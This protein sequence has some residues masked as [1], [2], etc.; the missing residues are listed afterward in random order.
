M[1][2]VFTSVRGVAAG[3]GTTVQAGRLWIRFPIRSL[4]FLI[5]I[6]LPA[7]LRPSGWLSLWGKD[8]R[9]EGLKTLPPSWILETLTSWNSQGPSRPVEGLLYFLLCLLAVWLQYG[10]S[11]DRGGY[12]T[13]IAEGHVCVCGEPESGQS[14]IVSVWPFKDEA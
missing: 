12:G 14:V 6:N 9:C 3:W 8:G 4:E 5:D 2:A 1:P 10:H 7:T 13:L 11:D